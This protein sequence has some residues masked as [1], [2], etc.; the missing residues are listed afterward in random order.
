[1]LILFNAARLAMITLNP[2]LGSRALAVALNAAPPGQLIIDDQYYSFS[3][4][5]FY[6][7]RTA[8]LLN[9]RKMNLEYGSYAPNAPA[10]FLTDV[11][12]PAR[13]MSQE[14]HYLT[15]SSAE[16]SRLQKL[17][18]KERLY[19]LHASGG[20]LLLTNQVLPNTKPLD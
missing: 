6:S 4:V 17:V 2:Y 14:R 18:S 11:E 19:L 13:W 7:N 5:F 8:L 10:V 15:T 12:F 20:K 3:S 1:M 9:G 16:L